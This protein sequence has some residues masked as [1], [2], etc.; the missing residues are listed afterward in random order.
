[1][2][3]HT[4]DF[5]YVKTNNDS[6]GVESS[7]RLGGSINGNGHQQQGKRKEKKTRVLTKIDF[8]VIFQ[9]DSKNLSG[10]EN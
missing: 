3:L 6:K 4:Q 10:N 5:E 8:Y 2:S 7:S 9:F 1:M